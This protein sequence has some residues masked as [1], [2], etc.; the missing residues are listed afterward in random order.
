MWVKAQIIFIGKMRS[1]SL[2]YCFAENFTFFRW[3]CIMCLH[4]MSLWSGNF[5]TLFGAHQGIGTRPFNS[6]YIEI[7]F[8]KTNL[9]LVCQSLFYNVLCIQ[10]QGWVRSLFLWDRS[11]S[12]NNFHAH[13]FNDRYGDTFDFQRKSTRSSN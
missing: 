7:K 12:L 8:S 1:A 10:K 9:F 3:I 13:F 2:Y 5:N 6:S 11:R 4:A